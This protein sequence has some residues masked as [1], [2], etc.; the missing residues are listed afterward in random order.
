[1]QQT[2]D[3][4]TTKDRMMKGLAVVGFV[5]LLIALAWLIFTVVASLP[6]LINNVANVIQS[7]TTYEL[8]TRPLEDSISHNTTV[9]IEWDKVGTTGV[10][11]FSYPCIDG[12][13]IEIRTPNQGIQSLACGTPYALGDITRADIT[14]RSVSDRFVDMP[15][16]ITFWPENDPETSVSATNQLAVFNPNISILGADDN[17]N[18]TDINDTDSDTV[19][20][21]TTNDETEDTDVPEPEPP[22]SDDDTD[23]ITVTT[24]PTRPTTPIYVTK[25]E[26]PKSDPNGTSNLQIRYLGVGELNRNNRFT[27]TATLGNNTTG[28]IRF[29]VKNTGTRT[30]ETWTYQA[31][32]PN[33]Q[34]YTAAPVKGLKPNEIATLTLGF[35]TS[36]KDGN[37]PFSVKLSTDRDTNSNDN[38]FNWSVQVR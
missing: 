32:L 6:T 2:P 18:D 4:P 36:N 22:T 12:V 7:D 33:G 26:I 21:N 29:S 37:Y 34:K 31:T 16:T 5:G 9:G 20:D 35:K 10:Y 19:V 25:Y 24:P 23:D 38:R 1:M 15:Y 28:A 27:P 30:S 8:T 3:S 14:I 17:D 13:S 11:E